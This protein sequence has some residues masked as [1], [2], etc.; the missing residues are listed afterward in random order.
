MNIVPYN[1]ETGEILVGQGYSITS[2]EQRKAYHDKQAYIEREKGSHWVA[3]YHEAIRS[4]TQDLT[5]T[6][7]GGIIRLLPYLRFK[8]EG[9]LINNG[10]PLKQTDIQ[11][12]FKRSKRATSDLLSELE[13]LGVIT[14][15][16]EGRSNVF[17]ISAEFHSMGQRGN[18]DSFTKLYQVRLSEVVD[19]LELNDVGL[20]YKVLPYFHYSEYYLCAN[21]DEQD[22][23]KLSYLDRETLAE[24]IGH[25][26][27]T[28]SRLIAKL[29]GRKAI[30]STKS[31]KSVRYLVHPDLMFRQQIE[32]DWTRS[33]R[34]LF[35]QH[36]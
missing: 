6:Q 3:S 17:Y 7:A 26:P 5:L 9:K 22:I 15:V 23:A 4:I 2:P 27:E 20:L 8:S 35:D 21:P 28:V 11:R 13:S 18:S 29:Q 10:K 31:G 30:L 32:T 1:R 16:K 14:I 33:V 25:E 36:D 34:K 19:G 24:A 12:I